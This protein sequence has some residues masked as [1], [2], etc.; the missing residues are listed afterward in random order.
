METLKASLQALEDLNKPSVDILLRKI[1]ALA[2]KNGSDF[3]RYEALQ[4]AQ[5]LVACASNTNHEKSCYYL[6]ALQEIRQRLHKPKEQF[7]PYFLALFSDR[8][9]PPLP[10]IVLGAARLVIMPTDV[11][12]SP[13]LGEIPQLLYRVPNPCCVKWLFTYVLRIYHNKVYASIYLLLVFFFFNNS[14]S[15]TPSILILVFPFAYTRFLPPLVRLVSSLYGRLTPTFTLKMCHSTMFNGS[16]VT[17][18][19]FR[20][21]QA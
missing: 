14:T 4:L 18:H 17:L 21:S 10:L 15:L 16:R 5:E 12:F 9:P 1:N 20:T 11:G 7:K 3:E 13:M 8:D 2:L 19:P 6:V